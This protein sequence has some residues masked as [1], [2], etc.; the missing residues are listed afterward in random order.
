MK[1]LLIILFIISFILTGFL[2]ITMIR[3]LNGEGIK[4]SYFITDFHMIKFIKLIINDKDKR[5]RKENL[6]IL[7]GTIIFT[8]L[9]IVLFFLINI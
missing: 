1:I 4:T 3:I 9:T 5:N 6:L 7:M 8:V 2:N